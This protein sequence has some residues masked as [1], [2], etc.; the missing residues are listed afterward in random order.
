LELGLQPS[1]YERLINLS[2]IFGA[3]L[4]RKKAYYI[5]TDSFQPVLTIGGPIVL[6]DNTESGSDIEADIPPVPVGT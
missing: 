4:T 3:S 6:S 2:R 5:F 1:R